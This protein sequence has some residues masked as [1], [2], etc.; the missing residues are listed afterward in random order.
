MA[1]KSKITLPQLEKAMASTTH[2]VRYDAM[3][4]FARSDI[5]PDATPILLA[6]LKDS[7]SGVV[8]TAVP[9]LGQIG[10]AAKNYGTPQLDIPQVVW[11]LIA[12]AKQIDRFS[13]L[14]GHY[15]KCVEA[16][17]KIAPECDLV[18]GLI[19]D[20]IGLT[21]W[22]HL[23]A[24]L[25]ALKTIGTEESIDLLKRAVEFWAPELDKKEL[26]IARE[27]VEGKR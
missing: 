16:L 4:E 23:K 8:G 19:H 5:S 25:Q 10:P 6:A 21:N 9:C 14:P 24:S 27:I 13:G 2:T 12:A 7:Y 22:H 3:L 26:R 18:V 11:D 20:Q 15:P 1:A 17:V